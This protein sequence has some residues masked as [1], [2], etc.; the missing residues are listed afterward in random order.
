MV[1]VLF[2]WPC[3][4]HLKVNLCD[5]CCVFS[6]AQEILPPGS[7]TGF[8]GLHLPFIG[9]TFTTERY[10]WAVLLIALPSG[11]AQPESSAVGVGGCGSGRHRGSLVGY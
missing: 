2:L 6:C 1:L 11:W 10:A 4:A 8:S 9:F 3:A 7:H 5:V